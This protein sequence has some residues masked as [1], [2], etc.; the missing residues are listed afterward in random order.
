MVEKNLVATV[1]LYQND[2]EDAYVLNL[3]AIDLLTTSF[4]M[5]RLPVG[6]K[7]M[8]WGDMIKAW[9]EDIEQCVINRREAFPIP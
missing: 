4:R 3:V 5:D 8:S 1:Q 6:G 2:I 7:S 9:K